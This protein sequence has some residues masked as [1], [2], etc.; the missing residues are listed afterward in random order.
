MERDRARLVHLLL[1]NLG[2][3]PIPVYV[4]WRIAKERYR[5]LALKGLNGPRPQAK[6]F[7]APEQLGDQTGLLATWMEA[8]PA[9]GGAA[10]HSGRK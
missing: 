5:G 3:R 1:S 6:C 10:C 8:A 4:L 2:H 7:V 9:V